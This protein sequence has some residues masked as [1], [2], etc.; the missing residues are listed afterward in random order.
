[1]KQTIYLETSVLSYLTGRPSRDLVTAARQQLTQ[2]WWDTKRSE[3]RLFISQPVLNEAADGD[4][5]KLP[6]LE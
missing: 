1:M 6:I 3:F 5:E 2:K 4:P